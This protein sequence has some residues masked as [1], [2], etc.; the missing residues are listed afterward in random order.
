MRADELSQRLQEE[1]NLCAERRVAALERLRLL[2]INQHLVEKQE[3]RLIVRKKR[4]KNVLS[5]RLAEL[6]L[7]GRT[8]TLDI[9]ALSPER[10]AAKRFSARE[11]NVI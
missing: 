4:R 3:R 10:F 8:S 1:Q 2:D 5:G 11:Y 7:D 9:T 6:I